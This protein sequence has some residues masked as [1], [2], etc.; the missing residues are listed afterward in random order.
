MRDPL[1]RAWH[2]RL[3]ET[4]FYGLRAEELPTFSGSVQPIFDDHCV[5][6]HSGSMPPRGQDLSDG[7]SYDMIVN[8][9]ASEL[10]S[11]DRIEPNDVDNSYLIH[12]VEGTQRVAELAARE[13]RRLAQTPAGSDR[14]R[15]EAP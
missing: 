7:V 6:C 1:V 2:A 11:M 12:K 4:G 13:E 9:A 8:V 14:A 3:R 10:S 5:A 15:R